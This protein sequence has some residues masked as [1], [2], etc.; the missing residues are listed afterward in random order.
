VQFSK[1]ERSLMRGRNCRSLSSTRE[2]QWM[3]C[4]YIYITSVFWLRTFRPNTWDVSVGRSTALLV[5]W[6][7]A[8]EGDT[9]RPLVCPAINSDQWVTT[10]QLG[11]SV[12]NARSCENVL[13]Q[14]AWGAFVGGGGG[15]DDVLR[16]LMCIQWRSRVRRLERLA[17]RCWNE[18][19][20]QSPRVSIHWS[21]VVRIRRYSLRWH[22]SRNATLFYVSSIKGRRHGGQKRCVVIS[23]LVTGLR[24]K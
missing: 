18:R 24:I 22:P 20:Q 6:L 12:I 7:R 8:E 10:G 3:V 5:C 9:N 14:A 1:W 13:R 23:P 2:R 15:D 4:I 16:V 19:A 21:M 11:W 17:S